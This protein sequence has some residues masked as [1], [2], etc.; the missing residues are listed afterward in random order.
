MHLITVNT[1]LLQD[2]VPPSVLLRD[3]SQL[4]NIY[5]LHR[6]VLMGLRLVQGMQRVYAKAKIYMP[7]RWD[8]AKEVRKQVPLGLAGRLEE[9]PP[10]S[11]L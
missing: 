11:K 9:S 6:R 3:R 1:F 7:L 4:L 8:D 10:P 5:P 2:A